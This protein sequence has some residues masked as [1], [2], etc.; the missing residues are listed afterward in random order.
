M[1]WVSQLPAVVLAH[2]PMCPYEY[3]WD[4]AGEC[5]AACTCP[6]FWPH[7]VCSECWRP[8]KR[9]RKDCSKHPTRVAAE[10]PS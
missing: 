1:N 2:H 10:D 5:H 4:V 6:Q 7:L 8:P 9:H 3:A